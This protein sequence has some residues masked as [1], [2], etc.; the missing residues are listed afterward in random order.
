[1]KVGSWVRRG[2]EAMRLDSLVRPVEG[3]KVGSWVRIGEARR[4]G[5]RDRG[6]SRSLASLREVEC[7]KS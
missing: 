6:A 1:M 3:G 2:E 4:L 7:V 5:S